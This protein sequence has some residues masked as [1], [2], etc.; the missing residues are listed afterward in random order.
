MGSY[1][2]FHDQKYCKKGKSHNKRKPFKLQ[3]EKLPVV[4]KKSG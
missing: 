1:Q 3:K 4:K 2:V